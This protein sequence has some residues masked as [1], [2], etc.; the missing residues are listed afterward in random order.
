MVETTS[1]IA[2]ENPSLQKWDFEEITNRLENRMSK[3]LRDT[4]HSQREI[5]KLIENIP[6]KVDSLSNLSLEQVCS[7]SRTD[8]Q[9]GL[10]NVSVTDTEVSNITR[11]AS[12]NSLTVLNR[13]WSGGPLSVVEPR[14]IRLFNV[15]WPA[16]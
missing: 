3:R 9:V 7:G 4:E 10:S 1:S 6:S 13:N 12:S 15:T 5:L 8:I 16:Q 2:E 11:N 14:Y